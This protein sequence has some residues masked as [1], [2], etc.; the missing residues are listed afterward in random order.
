MHYGMRYYMNRGILLLDYPRNQLIE[1]EGVGKVSQKSVWSEELGNTDI[2]N[3]ESDLTLKV[4][5]GGEKGKKGQ[6]GAQRGVGPMSSQS[7]ESC[8]GQE[9]A[10]TTQIQ[11]NTRNRVAVLPTNTNFTST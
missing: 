9:E 4:Q 7:Q 5:T 10:N 8:P 3:K 2:S 11:G 1:E 6:T